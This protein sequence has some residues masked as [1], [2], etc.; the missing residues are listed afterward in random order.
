MKVAIITYVAKESS[1]TLAK[2]MAA[3]LKIQVDV[4]D[5][6][7]FYGTPDF[8]RYDYVFAYGCS[9]STSHRKRLNKR[10]NTLACIDKVE[11]FKRLEKAGVNIPSWTKNWSTA[12]GACWPTTV[13]RTSRTGRKAEG[14]E[15]ID[16]PDE[17]PKGEL[18]TEYFYHKREYRI[19]VFN[20]E[21]VGRYYKKRTIKNGEGWHDFK[22]QPARGFEL[23]DDHC[24]RAAKALGID[25]V[26]FDVVAN[27]KKDFKV[28]EA[29]SGPIITD[30]AK[31]AII[32]FFKG[33]K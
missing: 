20:G 15:L 26:G 2:A 3:S 6:S 25:Y 16:Y 27:T 17:L 29:N 19:V 31:A 33:K 30:E 24:L 8:K 10:A 9:A 1:R 18:F 22:L 14:L 5:A 21:V 32:K 12:T 28:L 7:E 13:V 4:F 11:T 23:M